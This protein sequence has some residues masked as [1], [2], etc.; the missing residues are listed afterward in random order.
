MSSPA[1][2][3]SVSLPTVGNLPRD[4][5]GEVIGALAQPGSRA[6]PSAAEW[7]P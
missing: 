7:P 6:L 3:R 5:L 1:G 2:L 4:S